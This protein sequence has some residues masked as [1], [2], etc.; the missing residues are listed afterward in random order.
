LDVETTAGF[1]AF[2]CLVILSILHQNVC[3]TSSM[4]V[5]LQSVIDWNID[6]LS[7]AFPSSV[8][9]LPSKSLKTTCLKL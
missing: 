5:S 9:I 8:G 4:H 3:Y 6:M 1:S 7:E 2:F